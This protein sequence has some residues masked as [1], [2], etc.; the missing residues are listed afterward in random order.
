VRRRLDI[1]AIWAYAHV[2]LPSIAELDVR[3]FSRMFRALSDET[4]LRIVALLAHGELCVCHLEHALAT[5]QPNVSRALGILRAAGV[6]DRR[7][8]GSWV[9]YRL[10][11]QDAPEL[12]AVIDGVAR[13]LGSER[14]L[15]SD[16]ARLKK[17]CGP[18]ACA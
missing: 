11:A 17:S 8:D 4:R 16:L 13:A 12:Q 10:V 9:Y 6:V 1:L 15:R 2:V 3:P 7:R 5:S 14:T 18:G